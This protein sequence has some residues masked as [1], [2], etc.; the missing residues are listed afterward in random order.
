MTFLLPPGIG[1]LSHW[2]KRISLKRMENA[3]VS[4]CTEKY[5]S[6]LKRKSFEPR[7]NSN[8][9]TVIFFYALLR[10]SPLLVKVQKRFIWKKSFLKKIIGPGTFEH[11]YSSCWKEIGS[12]CRDKWI[13]RQ[14]F[15]EWWFLDFISK[16]LPSAR[17]Q[18]LRKICGKASETLLLV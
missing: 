7:N 15:A 12:S 3:I 5:I 4:C 1:G 18:K 8:L 10:L 11:R 14:N 9:N 2:Y 6:Q 13:K 17:F 16:L